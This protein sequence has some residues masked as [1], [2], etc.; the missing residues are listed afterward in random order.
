MCIRDSFKRTF[1]KALARTIMTGQYDP[2][3]PVIVFERSDK[4]YRCLL[5]TSDAADEN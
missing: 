5:Y 4:Q 2:D 3:D 1:R